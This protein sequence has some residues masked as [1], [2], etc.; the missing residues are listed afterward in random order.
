MNKNHY[1]RRDFFKV[2]S[3][4]L[5]GS[6]LSFQNSQAMNPNQNEEKDQIKI[7]E[8]RTLGRTGFKASDISMGC[9]GIKEPNVI[10]Y[11]YDHGV[12]YFDTAEGYGNGDSEKKIGEAMQ[13]MERDKIFITTKLVLRDDDT[14]EKILERFGKCQERLKTEYVDALYMHSIQ[15][16]EW[17]DNPHFHEAVKELKTAGRLKHAGISSHGP[18]GDDLDSMEKVLCAAAEDGRFDLMLLIYNFMNKEAGEKILE[19]CKKNN[20]G[21]SAMKTAPGVLKS[22]IFDPKNPSQEAEDYI[23]R[24]AKRGVSREEAIKRIERWSKGQQEDEIKT[25]P[26]LEKYGIKTEDQLFSSSIQ[27]VLNNKDMHT[28]CIAMRDFDLL[29]KVIPLSG[30]KLSHSNSEFLKNYGKI[31]NNQYCRHACSDCFTACP[32]GI[33]VSTIMRYAA[34]YQRQG[35]EKLAMQKYARLGGKDASLCETCDAFCLNSCPH[36]VNIQANLVNAHSLLTM[37]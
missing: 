22:E 9:I 25:R 29:D 30:T 37:V 27:W 6:T 3:L 23:E 7:K 20:V 28:T 34:Y 26:F 19:A 8:Y 10:R 21:T 13:F 12:N 35:R 36:N 4:A 11:A 18:R 31:F 17:F 2:G 14:K 1:S 15:K 16:I 5:A 32:H 33:P 24:V